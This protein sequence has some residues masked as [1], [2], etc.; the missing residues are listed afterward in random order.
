MFPFD[1]SIAMSAFAST[2]FAVPLLE[3]VKR[4]EPQVDP[5]TQFGA[6]QIGALIGGVLFILICVG[7]LFWCGMKRRYPGV[8]R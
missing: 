4:Q 6:G 5:E 2:A 8:R 7:L 1:S 3:V